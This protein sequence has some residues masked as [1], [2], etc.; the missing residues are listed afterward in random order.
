MSHRKTSA[1]ANNLLRIAL[2]A[3]VVPGLGCAMVQPPGYR[4]EDCAMSTYGEPD[5]FTPDYHW[6]QMSVPVPAWY[7][8]WK[9]KRNLPKPPQSPRF[10]PLPTRP[11]FSAGS[12]SNQPLSCFGQLPSPESWQAAPEEIPLQSLPANP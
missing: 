1:T 8:T 11:M 2:A 6:P 4:L 12:N 10:Q 5:G 9:A 3:L 7:A